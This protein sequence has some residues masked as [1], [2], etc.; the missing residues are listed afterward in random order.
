LDLVPDGALKTAYEGATDSLDG[1]TAI[2][3]QELA[4]LAAIDDART[5]V[6]ARPDLASQIGLIG[7]TPTEPYEAARSAFQAGHLDLA[8]ALANTASSIVSGAAAV[9][10]QRLI[11]VVVLTVAVLLLLGLLVSMVR[12]RS[13]R[14]RMLA[15]TAAPAPVAPDP[16]P[17]AA[18]PAPTEPYA[19]LAA[20]PATEHDEGGHAR[21]DL[22]AD[23]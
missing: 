14:R 2:A 1:A 19:T 9:G 6:G 12:R 21:G 13:R 5:N 20:D 11:L 15:L 8:I 17:F 16:S 3:N 7:E 22:P 18:D 10:Q 4:S 23:P